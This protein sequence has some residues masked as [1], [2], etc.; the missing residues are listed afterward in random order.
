[1]DIKATIESS[2]INRVVIT[3]IGAIFGYSVYWLSKHG[4]DHFSFIVLPALLHTLCMFT[5]ISSLS[6]QHKTWKQDILMSFIVSL[7][8]FA[9][10]HTVYGNLLSPE[11][12]S[13]VTNFNSTYRSGLAGSLLIF[14]VIGATQIILSAVP[15]VFYQVARDKNQFR[16]P[17]R[18]L[19]LNAWTNKL[20][21]IIAT[22]FLVVSCLI[23]ALWAGMFKL[24]GVNYFADLFLER[25]F[26]ALF[27]GS[28]FGLGTAIAR[29][30][31]NIIQSLLNIILLLFRVL[32]PVLAFVIILFLAFLPFIGLDKLFETNI[33]SRLVLTTIFMFVMFENAVIQGSKE[34]GG[35][36]KYFAW[37]VAVANL[38]LPALV[39]IS[40]YAI[41]LRV[42]QYGLTPDRIYLIIVNV[43]AGLYGVAYLASVGI[44]RKKW[45][46]GV[47]LAN[48]II[49]LVI[50][51]FAVAIHLP[52]LEP[53][54]LSARNQIDRLRSGAISPEKFDFA[55]LK[56]KLGHSGRVVFAE[57]ES[58][59]DLFENPVIA[60]RHATA[61]N[62]MSYSNQK[63]RS[64]TVSDA[65][66]MDVGAYML[67]VPETTTLPSEITKDWLKSSRQ[68]LINCKKYGT[69]NSRGCWILKADLN[70]DQ[71]VDILWFYG[72]IET[73][74]IQPDGTWLTGPKLNS[75][76]GYLNNEKRMKL[77]EDLRHGNYKFLQPK[78]QNLII[79]DVR[80]K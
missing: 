10:F 77:L 76:G 66:L 36:S 9:L 50:L 61:N 25:W 64:K 59:T 68:H 57:I 69:P 39:A 14:G 48:P 70:N 72:S 46:Q 31:P 24:I 52:P 3:S 41:F 35:F 79:D 27:T 73:K 20:T 75:D 17:Y 19:F 32:T 80:F 5:L 56:F 18:E 23:L 2:T 26:I 28:V 47:Y 1:M 78:Y 30:R 71:R 6:F 45:T 13:T 74:I 60:D 43:I 38:L 53:N 8:G 21:L 55:Y 37:L 11:A 33:M 16:F 15:L 58:D 54:E 62:Q 44:L 12:N 40:A 63:R 22:F 42:N 65:D 7:A 4:T 49:A 29:E 34:D 67:M 51:F